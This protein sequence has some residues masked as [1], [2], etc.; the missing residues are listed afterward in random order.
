MHRVSYLLT[1]LALVVLGL[2][3]TILSTSA[4]AQEDSATPPDHPLIG[5]WRLTVTEEGVSSPAIATWSAD[6]T[7]SDIT[8]P[9]AAI[10]PDFAV[11]ATPAFG[12]WESTG[13]NSGAFTAEYFYSD[14]EGNLRTTRTTSGEGQVSDD[15]E[16]ATGSFAYLIVAPDG[17]VVHAGQGTFE[18]TRLAVVPM[19]ELPTPAASPAA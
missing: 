2:G 5:T 1:I 14:G 19:D 15:G 6:G 11:F 12:A 4:T 13:A 16:T 10:A 18:A 8:P 7:Y 3:A 9:V 17:T